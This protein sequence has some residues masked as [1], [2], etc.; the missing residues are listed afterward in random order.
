MTDAPQRFRNSVDVALSPDD[1]FG[2]LARADT[3]PL[4]W[5]AAYCFPWQMAI[6]PYL[7]NY[8]AGQTVRVLLCDA[9]LWAPKDR[10]RSHWL[11]LSR[12]PE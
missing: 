6:R 1:L 5:S 2:V 11:Q 8:R 3:W 10:S 9:N 4:S 7:G 12:W